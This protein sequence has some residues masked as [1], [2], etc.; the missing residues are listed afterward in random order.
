[1]EEV[2]FPRVVINTTD[3]MRLTGLSARSARRMLEYVRF[4][5]GLRPKALVPVRYFLECYEEFTPEE[6]RVAMESTTFLIAF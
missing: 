3:V 5:K 4:V 6:V 2:T 1:M